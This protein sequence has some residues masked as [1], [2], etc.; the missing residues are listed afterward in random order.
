M[1]HLDAD[2]LVGRELY[3]QVVC[4]R[5]EHAQESVWIATANVKEMFVENA[6]GRF[7]SIIEV[8]RALAARGVELRVLHADL[9]S[10]PFRASFDR[11]RDLV[12]GGLSL[13]I[14]PRVHLKVV[15]VDRAW[16]YLGSANLTGAGLGAKAENRRNFEA[17][18][19]TEDFDTIDRIGAL[20]DAIWTGEQCSKCALWRSCPDPLGEP[21][22]QSRSGL[23]LGRSR[24]LRRR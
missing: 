9:P 15:L 7:L 18:F 22:K 11:S 24:R 8:F 13:K 3:R 5:L 20:F 10:R 12:R 2:L 23:R 4:D 1:R 16:L 14:C 6:R 17:G 19:V 21:P